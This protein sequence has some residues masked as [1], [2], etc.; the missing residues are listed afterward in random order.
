MQPTRRH[1]EAEAAFR[2]FI[3]EG[4]L[5]DPDEI[6]YGEEEVLFFW[7]GPKLCVAFDL[8]DM[9]PEQNT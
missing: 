8:E 4:G 3:D 2:R 9:P 5:A 7:H 1:H 6:R